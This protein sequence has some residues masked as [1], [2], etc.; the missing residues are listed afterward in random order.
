MN[1]NDNETPTEVTPI[2]S[3]SGG[4]P[5]LQGIANALCDRL[6]DEV[7]TIEALLVSRHLRVLVTIMANW[8]PEN[9]PEVEDRKRVVDELIQEIKRANALLP[10][11]PL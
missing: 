1:L 5:L 6:D 2:A 8:S 3:T 7:P 9:Q 10:A 11:F 4:Y